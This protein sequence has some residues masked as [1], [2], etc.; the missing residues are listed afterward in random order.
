MKTINENIQ[1]FTNLSKAQ[2][3]F[4]KCD[5]PCHLLEA[6]S[7]GRATW[8]VDKSKTAIIDWPRHYILLNEK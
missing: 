5:S 1:I 7:L 6:L 3:Y 2:N 8:F 4:E